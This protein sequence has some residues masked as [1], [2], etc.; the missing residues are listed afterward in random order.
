MMPVS[1]RPR[2]LVLASTYP[3]WANDHELSFVHDL[4]KRL[5]DRFEVVVL[6][7]HAP[8]AASRELLDGVQIV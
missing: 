1:P 8:G 6:C 4:A 3:R 7:P 2:L 5:A